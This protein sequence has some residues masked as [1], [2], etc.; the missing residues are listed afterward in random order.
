M[1]QALDLIQW[2]KELKLSAHNMIVDDDILAKAPPLFGRCESMATKSDGVHCDADKGAF[3]LMAEL[4]DSCLFHQ[5]SQVELLF[6]EF[7][8]LMSPR[9]KLH[10][11]I[12]L[13]RFL[14]YQR[15]RVGDLKV[16]QLCDQLERRI[17]SGRI[18]SVASGICVH[19]LMPEN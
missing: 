8:P 5:F 4:F 2:V 7:F 18:Q 1:S 9:W 16:K 6:M 10:R 3:T 17:L 15:F 14:M 19:W 13:F 11:D 12:W